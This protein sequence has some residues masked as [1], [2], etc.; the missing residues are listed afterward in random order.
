MSGS[1]WFGGL[2]APLR[3]GKTTPFEG[4]VRV[5]A[6]FIDFS[7]SEGSRSF[8]GLMHVSDWFPTLAS[9]AGIPASELPADLDG[10]NLADSLSGV[11]DLTSTSASVVPRDGVLLEMWAA[12]D[13]PFN[14]Q[15][16]AYRLGDFKLINGSVRDPNYYWES[17]TGR[18]LNI[19]RPLWSSYGFEI[20]IK[21]ME[22]IFGAGPFDTLRILIAHKYVHVSFFCHIEFDPYSTFYLSL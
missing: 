8:N 22:A 2:N 19:S 1:P 4:G 9:F 14:E 3:G 15:L 20:L 13:T 11:Q 5:P 17:T 16:E 6:V 10:F 7:S 12:Y 18:F 21:G